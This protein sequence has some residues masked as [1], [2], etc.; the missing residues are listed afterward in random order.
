M[1]RTTKRFGALPV[2]PKGKQVTNVKVRG[3]GLRTVVSS[4]LT[5][6]V[7]RTT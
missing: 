1:A 7:S 2:K 4:G 5:I 3:D 6:F